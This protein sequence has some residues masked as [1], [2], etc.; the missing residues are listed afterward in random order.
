MKQHTSGQR[1]WGIFERSIEQRRARRRG[2]CNVT[3]LARSLVRYR[4]PNHGRSVVEVLITVVSFVGLWSLMW[5]SLRAGYGLYLLL[6]S[7]VRRSGS[8]YSTFSISSSTRFGLAV[9]HG[10]CTRPLFSA[11]HITTFQAFCAGSLPTSASITSIISAAEF[12]FTACLSRSACIPI[13]PMWAG[14]RWVRVLR[15]CA[16]CFGMR[17]QNA[18]LRFVN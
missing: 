17:R 15:V 10:T 11:V 2:R 6:A 7:S 18:L 5:L 9:R 13:L 3:A 4:E 16:A 12:H 1:A 14:S 8:G